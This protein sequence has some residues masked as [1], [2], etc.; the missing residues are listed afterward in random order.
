MRVIWAGYPQGDSSGK[1][2]CYMP[3]GCSVVDYVIVSADIQH[4]ISRFSIHPLTM[5]SDHSP[6]TF[7]LKIQPA[8]NQHCSLQGK[9][10]S[11]PRRVNK[12]A[13]AQK[14]NNRD[15]MNALMEIDM[16]IPFETTDTS[17]KNITTLLTGLFPQTNGSRFQKKKCFPHNTWFDAEFK[18]QKRKVN[19]AKKKY[20]CNPHIP[21]Y[22]DNYHLEKKKFKKLI[23]LKKL[24]E[25][26]HFHNKLLN[27]CK[28]DP[29]E[30]WKAVKRKPEVQT[31]DISPCSLLQYFLKLNTSTNDTE[32]PSILSSLFTVPQLDTEIC[33]DEVLYT[34]SQLKSNRAPGIDGLPTELY[35]ILSSSFIS[36]FTLLFNN[37]LNTG[38]FPQTRSNGIITPIHKG[39]SKEDP[40]NYRGITLL[41]TGGKIF[42][43]ILH[44]RLSE[45]LEERCLISESQFGFRRNRSTTDCI[46]IL[47]TLV[48]K[49]LNTG[50][51]LY[52]CYVDLKKAFDNVDHLLLWVKLAKIG[53]SNKLLSVL[54]SMYRNAASCIKL[55]SNTATEFF[56]CKKGVRQGCILSPLLFNIYTADLEKELKENKSGIEICDGIF[57]DA[58]M[59]ADD[60]VLLSSSASG[61]K[62]HL[63]TLSDYCKQ[64][65]L[66]VN[67]EMTKISVFG[68]DTDP[69]TYTWNGMD[70][71]K[72]KSYKY[73]GM[74]FSTNGKFTRAT[75]HLSDK[76]KK[77]MFSLQNNPKTTGTPTYSNCSTVI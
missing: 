21:S 24:Q 70:L 44:S 4:I 47:N 10:V 57:L 9:T 42:A 19:D 53:V 76:S 1:Y 64:W 67:T 49:S 31:L 37:I 35:K 38:C 74:W 17:V 23:K 68:K 29:R 20:T 36:T 6:L 77:A 5:Y 39:G 51:P 15:V 16:Q 25:Y 61:L 58:L 46:F 14:L 63:H 22:R 71:E 40:K 54:Q 75:E 72:V 12:Q 69:Q 27:L 73:L 41:N 30:F 43:S 62:K 33:E 65:K 56:P 52:V 8:V 13:I 2:T 11:L 66:E 55:S 26:V 59:Y 7:S 45:W 50:K 34:I 48:E 28:K 3:N 18:M 32:L 60:I